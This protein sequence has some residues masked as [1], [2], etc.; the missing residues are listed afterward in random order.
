MIAVLT[1]SF[2]IAFALLLTG[3]LIDCSQGIN[4]MFDVYS[5]NQNHII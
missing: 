2:H 1:G 3:V 5:Q 4:K